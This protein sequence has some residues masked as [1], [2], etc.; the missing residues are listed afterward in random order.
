MA[1]LVIWRELYKLEVT[2]FTAWM[3]ISQNFKVQTEVHCHATSTQKPHKGTSAFIYVS[4][5][6]CSLTCR[7]LTTMPGPKG[8][9]THTSLTATERIQSESPTLGADGQYLL[10]R[11]KSHGRRLVGKAMTDSLRYADEKTKEQRHFEF[12]SSRV[13]SSKAVTHDFGK[14][15]RWDVESITT[16]K[17]KIWNCTERDCNRTKC[18]L[19]FLHI[20]I[21]F[22][23][24]FNNLFWASPFILFSLFFTTFHMRLYWSQGMKNNME[25]TPKRSL[26]TRLSWSTLQPQIFF[27]LLLCIQVCV[28]VALWHQSADGGLL[29]L[30]A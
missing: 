25:N 14:H 22:F 11:V 19:C 18:S 16:K 10:H 5:D 29:D 1:F 26:F 9:V 3:A 15:L 20:W 28:A 12:H 21:C 6:T 13:V 24:S 17:Y 2:V 7:C 4:P 8:T 27:V 30:F 23:V